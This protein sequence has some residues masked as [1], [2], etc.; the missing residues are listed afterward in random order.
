MSSPS[1]PLLDQE[2][3]W[4][5]VDTFSIKKRSL[6]SASDIFITPCSDTITR[7]ELSSQCQLEFFQSEKS[8]WTSLLPLFCHWCSK[9]LA[10]INVIMPTRKEPL[11]CDIRD[12]FLSVRILPP[13]LFLY[14]LRIQLC[15]RRPP[16]SVCPCHKETLNGAFW[17][18]LS[19]APMQRRPDTAANIPVGLQCD[20]RCS[21]PNRH[22]K[23]VSNHVS[24][25]S[26]DLWLQFSGSKFCLF[27]IFY[28]ENEVLLPQR[29]EDCAYSSFTTRSH[30]K[31][32]KKKGFYQL[33]WA[34][35]FKHLC[36]HILCVSI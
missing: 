33:E 31:K 24:P 9:D 25:H 29:K 18:L 22:V 7:K 36:F 21:S 6:P 11:C 4:I 20:P 5:P 23:A 30:I 19:P 2:H 3:G 17:S 1:P 26:R 28:W 8:S 15:G 35:F 14:S 16:T 10:F 32:R 27:Q 12:P 34:Y 13:S